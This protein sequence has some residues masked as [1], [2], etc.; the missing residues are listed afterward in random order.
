MSILS[1]IESAL[2]T[3]EGVTQA[4]LDRVMAEAEAEEAHLK[5]EV[6]AEGGGGE[7]HGSGEGDSISCAASGV[8]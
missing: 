6:Q 5:S 1:A 7:Q 4:D 3:I 8:R 2:H